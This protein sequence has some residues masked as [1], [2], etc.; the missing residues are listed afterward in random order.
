MEDEIFSKLLKT[1]EGFLGLLALIAS[2]VYFI[3]RYIKVIINLLKVFQA[4]RVFENFNDSAKVISE[5]RVTYIFK[6]LTLK[7][8]SQELF[9][10]MRYAYE[11]ETATK[12]EGKT[13]AFKLNELEE[14]AVVLAN[15][16]RFVDYYRARNGVRILIFLQH[17]QKSEVSDF[18]QHLKEY[19][20]KTEV[21][22]VKII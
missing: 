5:K 16:V 21:H 18:K 22:G 8:T 1:N 10:S 4:E 6:N 15:I 13:I 20:N 14:S 9:D 17:L 2:G 19:V 3:F 12:I 7:K 11:L